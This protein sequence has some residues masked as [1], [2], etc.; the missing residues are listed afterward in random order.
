MLSG[1]IASSLWHR[2]PLLGLSELRR[3]SK[4]RDDRSRLWSGGEFAAPQ[5]NFRSIH[6]NV[7]RGCDPDAD[8]F[9]LNCGYR[10]PDAAIDNDL[11]TH[12]A[13]QN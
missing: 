12:A 8:L 9:A 11:L 6:A 7:R 3:T 5:V 4:S 13:C 2:A 1:F 10:D